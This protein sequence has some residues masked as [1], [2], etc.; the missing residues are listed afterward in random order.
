MDFIIA[1]HEDKQRID[2]VLARKYPDISRGFLQSLCKEE[3][4]LVNKKAQKSGYKV[5]WGD[6]VEVLY[7]IESIGSVP[8]ITLPI[9]YEDENVLAIDKPAGVLS[10]ALSKFKEEASVASFLRQHMQRG[11]SD[12][13]IRY[14]IVHRL[15]RATSGVMLCAKNNTTMKML[16]EQ[17]AARTVQKTY[18]A[19]VSGE[20]SQAK[21]RIDIPIERNPKAP[22]T[23]RPGNRGKLAQTEYE[24]ISVGQNSSH[25]RLQPK[26]GR[27]HQLRVHMTHIGCPIVG[28][29][30]YDGEPADRLYLHAHQLEISIPGYNNKLFEA[31]IPDSFAQK[32]REDK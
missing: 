7:D 3:K 22:A 25:V 21:A 12:Y 9:L 6:T 15:D 24:V 8:D 32:A 1:P 5:R 18:I 23:F 28:D 19:V 2:Y 20:P 10:H 29:V 13:D 11:G 17:F 16:Q 4:V 31:A 26:T 27:T 14:G 30:L